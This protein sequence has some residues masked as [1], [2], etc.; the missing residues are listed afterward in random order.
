[1]PHSRPTV[2]ESNRVRRSGRPSSPSFESP[3]I[4]RLIEASDVFARNPHR[5]SLH[6]ASRIPLASAA[7]QIC[8]TPALALRMQSVSPEFTKKLTFF[9]TL[10]SSPNDFEIVLERY[11]TSQAFR[12]SSP[13]A[14]ASAAASFCCAA[15]FHELFNHGSHVF[16]EIPCVREI[17]AARL[18]R[19]SLRPFRCLHGRRLGSPVCH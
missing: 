9:E 15:C 13:S 10:Q 6:Q 1:M 7:R 19:C 3:C 18:R 2:I 17:S 8:P 16:A 14:T 4:C 5:S 11:I 12:P